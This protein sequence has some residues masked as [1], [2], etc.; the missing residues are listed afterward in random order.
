GGGGGGGQQPDVL[1]RILSG[2]EHG[3]EADDE[4]DLRVQ[5]RNFGIFKRKTVGQTV[6]GQAIIETAYW[7]VDQCIA[8]NDEAPLAA[9]WL[10][11]WMHNVGYRHDTTGGD[12]GDV[13]YAI[14]EL[15]YALV[16][17]NRSEEQ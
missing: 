6:E 11:E 7:F 5:F 4:I 9:H 12:G 10:H 15:L 8:A 17:S 13:A 16:R 14:G 3:T 2:S 1:R